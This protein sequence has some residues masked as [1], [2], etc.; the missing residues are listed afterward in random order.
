[1]IQ[2]PEYTIRAV[3]N[4]FKNSRRYSQ[5]KVDHRYQRHR[6]QICHLCQR[7]RAA[8]CHRFQRHRWQICHRYQPATPASNFATSFT[9]VVDTGGKFAAGV[10]DMVN[11]ELQIYPRIFEKF[12]TVLMG[13]SGAKNLVTLSLLSVSL[14]LIRLINCFC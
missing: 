5:L 1:M 10:N 14:C 3:S 4:F 13:Y 9:S 8:N 7:H 11:L 12:E 2:A 6:W